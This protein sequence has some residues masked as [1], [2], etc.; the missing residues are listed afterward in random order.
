MVARLRTLF[1]HRLARFETGYGEAPGGVQWLCGERL[2]MTELKICM[3]CSAV[4]DVTVSGAPQLHPII[5]LSVSSLKNT[6]STRS[7]VSLA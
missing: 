6:L 7:T 5:P 1:G 3:D 4:S 2:W